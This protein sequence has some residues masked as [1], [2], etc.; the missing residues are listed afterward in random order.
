MK[1]TLAA[2]AKI[3]LWL[4][5]GPRAPDGFHA[6]DTLFCALH[7]ADT[8]VVR[9]VEAATDPTLE[10]AFADPLG[11]VP[12][13]GPP[14]R[15][16]VVRAARAFIDRAGVAGAPAIRLTKR[17]PAGAGLGGGSSDAAA[18]LR[19]LHRLHPGRL[20]PAT[21]LELGAGLGS[22]V[23]FFVR[24][25]PLARGTGRGEKLAPLPALPRRPVVVVIPPDP[26]ATG[27][28][29]GWLDE[30]RS[31]SGSEGVGP[32]GGGGSRERSEDAGSGRVAARPPGPMGW[33]EIEE[34]A[35]NDFEGPVY[36][37]HPALGALRDTL[38]EHGARPALLAGSGSTVFGVFR[39]PAEA[40]AAAA[41]LR[42]ADDSLR[43]VVTVTR[44]R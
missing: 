38:L 30:D 15:N 41:S 39:D 26:I 34:R 40:E 4:R 21:L 37:R 18:V 32:V 23:P 9:M 6:V 8:V 25:R 19:A 2:P 1:V 20:D 14:E 22:D 36:A 44:A 28:A 16:L 10:T 31:A 5:V 7:L 13:L 43:V 11:A 29:Y 33:D 12:A 3:N 27:E 42:S 24:G 17:I 35:H